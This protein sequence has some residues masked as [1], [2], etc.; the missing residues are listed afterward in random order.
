VI[1]RNLL[2]PAGHGEWAAADAVADLLAT[3]VT[4]VE[5]QA[6]HISIRV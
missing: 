1:E 3:S 6:L 2:T 5:A 4:P